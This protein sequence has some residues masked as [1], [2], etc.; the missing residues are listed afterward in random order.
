[1]LFCQGRCS[2]AREGREGSDYGASAGC[3]GGVE[4]LS[5]RIP[6]DFSAGADHSV[7]VSRSLE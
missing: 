1:M 4:S 6:D 7:G 5:E 2:D 3:A